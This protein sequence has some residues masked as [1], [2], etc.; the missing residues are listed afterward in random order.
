VRSY[1]VHVHRCTDAVVPEIVGMVEVPDKGERYPFR[2][3]AELREIFVWVEGP[4]AHPHGSVP[5][6]GKD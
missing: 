1:I 3:F 5:P 4:A 6:D 2:S